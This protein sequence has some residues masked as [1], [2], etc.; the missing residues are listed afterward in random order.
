MA[1][2]YITV[3]KYTGVCY[4]ESKQNKFRGRPDKIYWVRFRDKH[5][6]LRY[7]RCGRASEGWTPEAAQ[8]KRYQILEEERTGEY[9]P[10]Q[11]RKVES[12]S[13]NQFVDV[14]YLPWAKANKKW[15]ADDISRYRAW[16]RTDLGDKMLREIAPA[17]IEAILDKM[18]KA[19]KANATSRQV[20]SL[21]RHMFNKATEWQVWCGSN[22]CSTIKLPKL[23][24]ARER[25]L[26]KD[27]AEQ[28]LAA[29]R[30][31][32]IQVSQ[33]ASSSLYTGMRLREV[34]GL[35]WKDIDFDHNLITI[36]DTK[37]SES[38]KV[39]IT[40]PVR[41]ILK[42]LHIGEPGNFLFTN[43]KGEQLKT[44]SK[45]FWRTVKKLGLNDGIDDN[46]QQVSFHS[47]RHTFASWAVMS[48]T[49]LF[50]LAKALGHKTTAMAERYSHLA[51]DS[52]RLAFEKVAEFSNQKAN[53]ENHEI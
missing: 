44:L 43:N 23:N 46:R 30:E 41:E 36:L 1:S 22:P 15:P 8:Q 29:L 6:K 39:F 3:K 26:S 18:Q 21:I 4:S 10:K 24:N 40:P 27:E 47:L 16:I 11:Q 2:Q 45:T 42:E 48:G 12:I 50:H 49:P 31:T 5:G 25:F 34:F 9:K 51:P 14:Q 38:R 37:N 28:L 13:L 32:S 7:E 19:G 53:V 17:D 52:Q 33:T 20:Y 35:K